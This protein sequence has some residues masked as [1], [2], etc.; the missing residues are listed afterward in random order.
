MLWCYNA[1]IIFILYNN[2][3][4]RKE[5]KVIPMVRKFYSS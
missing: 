2:Q 1:G 3:S 4:L 5:N